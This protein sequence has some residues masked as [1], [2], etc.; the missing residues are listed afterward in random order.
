[1]VILC[2]LYKIR[3]NP[4]NPPYGALPYRMCQC[5]LH[6]VVWSLIGILIRLLAAKPRNT[7]DFYSSLSVSVRNDLADPVFDSM[8]WDWRVSR[9]GPMLFDWPNLLAPFLSSIVFPF[10]FYFL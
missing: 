10:P 9:A 3:C 5:G 4:M 2:I 1:M 6:A 7:A 8:V